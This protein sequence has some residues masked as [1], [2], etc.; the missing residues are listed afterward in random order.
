MGEGGKSDGRRVPGKCRSGRLTRRTRGGCGNGWWPGETPDFGY[1]VG[2]VD[3]CEAIIPALDAMLTC[4]RAP[5]RALISTLPTALGERECSGGAFVSEQKAATL[6]TA[7]VV[8]AG[9]IEAT[10]NLPRG[11]VRFITRDQYGLE[12]GSCEMFMAEWRPSE[13]R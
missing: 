11:S 13:T 7:C 6:E 8:T 1:V 3:V 5:V 10:V 12:R 4:T 2:P 9:R